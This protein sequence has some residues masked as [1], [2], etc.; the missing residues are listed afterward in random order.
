MA[1]PEDVKRGP[2]EIEHPQEAVLGEGD[3]YPRPWRCQRA[4]EVGEGR[5]GARGHGKNGLVCGRP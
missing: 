2:L 3:D 1:S 5:R 4:V